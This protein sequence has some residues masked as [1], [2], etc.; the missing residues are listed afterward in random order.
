[1][2]ILFSTLLLLFGC[3]NNDPD[4]PDFV[5]PGEDNE[6]DN[7]M[8]FEAMPTARFTYSPEFPFVGQQVV[9]N[10]TSS[11]AYSYAWD[12]GDDYTSTQKSPVHTFGKNDLYKVNLT[13]Y[14]KSGV[15]KD[16]TMEAIAVMPKPTNVSISKYKVNK[17][18]FTDSKGRYWDDKASDGPDIHLGIFKS[19]G[20]LSWKEDTYQKDITQSMI[21]YTKNITINYTNLSKSYKIVMFDYDT[22][23]DDTMATFTFTPKS[24]IPSYPSEVTLKSGDFSITLY[25]SWSF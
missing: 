3:N 5:I 10:N 20:T 13:V 15:K 25:L 2:V 23:F 16:Y 14:S 21:P 11:N 7:G 17:I 24:Y 19:D 6:S 1:M 18:S 22:W 12:F 9:F 4:T 8:A